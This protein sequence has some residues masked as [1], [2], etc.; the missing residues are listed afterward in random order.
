MDV[1]IVIILIVVAVIF[2]LL[3]IFLIPGFTVAGVT[4]LVLVAVSVWYAYS[5]IGPMAGHITLAGSFLFTGIAIWIFLKSKTLERMSLKTNVTGTVDEINE[6]LIRVGDKGITVSRLAP[7][8]KVK[9]NGIVVEA[10]TGSEFI[11]QKQEIVVLEV[12]KT[13]VLVEKTEII[14]Q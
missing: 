13:N 11:D 12:F 2:L 14:Q 1:L 7:M 3:E 9:V 5:H 8:G 10:K 6:N 4:G